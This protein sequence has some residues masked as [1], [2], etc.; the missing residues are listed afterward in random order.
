MMNYIIKG[1]VLYREK[2]ETVLARIKSVLNSRQKNICA[3]DG[4]CCMSTEVRLREDANDPGS[5]DVRQ[6][7]YVL[8][9]S[10]GATVAVARPDYAPGQ[11]P[12]LEGWPVSHM[13]RVNQAQLQMEGRSYQLTMEN[14]Q[15]YTLSDPA[16]NILLRLVHRGL[17]GGWNLETDADFSGGVLCGLFLFCRYIEKEN[18]FMVV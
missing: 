4:S 7:E 12:A 18:E 9:D 10:S 1:G 2:G 17:L 3:P 14:S 13:P 5:D 11:D 8:L 16:G 15:Y 6:R